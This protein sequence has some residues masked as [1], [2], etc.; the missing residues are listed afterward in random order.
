LF[1]FLLSLPFI[2]DL[3]WYGI[4]HLCLPFAVFLKALLCVLP[5]EATRKWERKFWLGGVTG[6]LVIGVA[7]WKI[8]DEDVSKQVRRRPRRAW[9][10]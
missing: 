3:T 1:S 10:L 4:V 6:G 5:S 7:I 2:E 8:E 9:S